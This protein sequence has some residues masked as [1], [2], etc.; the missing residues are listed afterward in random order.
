MT[1]DACNPADVRTHVWL[2]LGDAPQPDE[3]MRILPEYG[4]QSR[5][6]GKYLQGAP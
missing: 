1:T 4:G 2:M 5:V 6:V 3:H